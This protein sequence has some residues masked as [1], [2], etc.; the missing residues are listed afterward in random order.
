MRVV[1]YLTKM[2]HLANQIHTNQ[3][4]YL[5]TRITNNFKYASYQKAQETQ[6]ENRHLYR[7]CLSRSILCYIRYGLWHRK[8]ESLSE[9][10]EILPDTSW[11]I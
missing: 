6:R 3:K 11:S 5:L 7:G 4:S 1:T 10:C 9:E 2:I 8:D